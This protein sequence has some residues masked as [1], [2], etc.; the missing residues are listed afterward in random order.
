MITQVFQELSFSG[1]VNQVSKNLS[2]KTVVDTR[3]LLSIDMLK[4]VLNLVSRKRRPFV[5]SKFTDLIINE[6]QQTVQLDPDYFKLRSE[7]EVNAFP[8]DIDYLTLD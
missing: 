4:N 3:H 1:F 5:V 6:L 2:Q 7:L 8:F